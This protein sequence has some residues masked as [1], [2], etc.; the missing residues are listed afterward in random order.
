MYR[1]PISKKTNKMKT[2]TRTGVGSTGEEMQPDFSRRGP[3]AQGNTARHRDEVPAEHTVPTVSP[4]RLTGGWEHA[5]LQ[6][7]ESASLTEAPS[8]GGTGHPAHPK[9]TALGVRVR[10]L[11][12]LRSLPLPPLPHAVHGHARSVGTCVLCLPASLSLWSWAGHPQALPELGLSV[13]VRPNLPQ[14]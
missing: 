10:S 8:P 12:L 5:F 1:F 7:L 6:G 14:P 3:R 9:L 2:E 11:L 13:R 4:E